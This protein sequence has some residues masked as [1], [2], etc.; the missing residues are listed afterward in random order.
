MTGDECGTPTALRCMIFALMYHRLD[1][2]RFA[3]WTPQLIRLTTEVQF[4]VSLFIFQIFS[5][6]ISCLI[7]L[8][9]R[10]MKG[11]ITDDEIKVIAGMYD[12]F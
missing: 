7:G 6:T 9:C 3:A 2:A 1:E 4:L 5:L 12:S 10:G 11:R 8:S